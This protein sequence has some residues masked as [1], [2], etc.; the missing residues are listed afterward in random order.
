MLWKPET[1]K[2]TQGNDVLG[3]Y[4]KSANSRRM[5]CTTCGGH[6][7]TEHPEWRVINVYAATV[8]SFP[9]KP[10]LHINYAETVLRMRDGLPKLKDFPKQL[11]GTGQAIAE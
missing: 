8:P 2:I 10:A 9:F 11:G 1:V 3:T 6:V 4:S 7:M 5:F